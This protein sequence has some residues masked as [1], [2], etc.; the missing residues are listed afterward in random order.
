MMSKKWITNYLYVYEQRGEDEAELGKGFH[1]HCILEKPKSKP[2]SHMIT[3]LSNS[4]NAVCNSSRISF[5]L[6]L[7]KTK[8]QSVFSYDNRIK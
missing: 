8:K 5:S 4:A 6:Y 2:Y 1:F 3:E 7:R